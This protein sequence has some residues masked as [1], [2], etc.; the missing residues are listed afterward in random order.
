MPN[1]ISNILPNVAANVEL[2]RSGISAEDQDVK[3]LSIF[4][5]C[6]T[7]KIIAVM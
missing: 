4:D 6:E 1:I 5:M 7:F 2:E 3:E